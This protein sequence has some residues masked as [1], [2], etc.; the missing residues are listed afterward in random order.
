MLQWGKDLLLVHDFKTRKV[1]TLW[2]VCRFK[3][4]PGP[5]LAGWAP[6]GLSLA[7]P[8]LLCSHHH[9]FPHTLHAQPPWRDWWPARGHRHGSYAS[10]TP[11]RRGHRDGWARFGDESAHHAGCCGERCLHHCWFSVFELFFGYA[12]HISDVQM[13]RTGY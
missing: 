8:F 7:V 5:V 1:V 4:Y 3:R 10:S 11:Q 2:F 12:S 6:K 9:W 13:V